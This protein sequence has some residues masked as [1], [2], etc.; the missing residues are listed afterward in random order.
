M[1]KKVLMIV[2]DF[3]ESYEAM[4]PFQALQAMGLEVDAACPDKRAGE[5]VATAVHDFEGDQTYTEKRGHNFVLNATFDDVDVTTYDGLYL[6][7]GRAPEYLRLNESVLGAVRHFFEAGKPVGMI[8]HGVQI[9][10]GA[11]VCEGRTMTCYPAC[12]P[13]LER[14]GG[15]Y[16][17]NNE[18]FTNAEVDGNLVSGPAW[19]AHPAVLREFAQLL[20]ASPDR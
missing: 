18:T 4:V 9:L 12:A 20:G 1:A 13:E 15:T 6:P 17:P 7:G 2:G 8:C 10:T 11:G 5:A 3:V 19:P 16:V 14:A